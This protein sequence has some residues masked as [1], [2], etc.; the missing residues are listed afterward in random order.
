MALVASVIALF[1]L[2][3]ETLIYSGN[4]AHIVAI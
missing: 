3:K 2:L 4:P 1:S